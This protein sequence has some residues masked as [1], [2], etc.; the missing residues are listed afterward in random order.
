ML[1]IDDDDEDDDDDD[2]ALNHLMLIR[3][4][5]SLAT[6][7]TLQ[8]LIHNVTL[9]LDLLADIQAMILYAHIC[10]LYALFEPVI[11]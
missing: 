7:T 11:A 2:S 5:W 3:L 8:K 6:L 9:K 4:W 1:R 10:R